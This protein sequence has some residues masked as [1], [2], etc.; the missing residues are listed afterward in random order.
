LNDTDI[1]RIDALMNNNEQVAFAIQRVNYPYFKL[2]IARKNVHL[3]NFQ[4]NNY[5]I[6]ESPHIFIKYG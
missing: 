3:L 2:V 6:N 1:I 4:I 5:L